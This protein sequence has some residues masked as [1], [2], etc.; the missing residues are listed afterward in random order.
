MLSCLLGS[1]SFTLF[2]VL[3][4]K[5]GITET[6]I[7]IAERNDSITDTLW[8]WDHLFVILSWFIG[9]SIHTRHLIMETKAWCIAIDACPG[10][11][12]TVGCIIILIKL[13]TVLDSLPCTCLLSSWLRIH[14]YPLPV[15]K[16]WLEGLACHLQCT[17]N[18]QQLFSMVYI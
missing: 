13:T 10:D 2:T 14:L 15:L 17:Y 8:H 5:Y 16:P 4:M 11:K 7:I 3:W 12:S 6:E 9:S 1:L 18:V